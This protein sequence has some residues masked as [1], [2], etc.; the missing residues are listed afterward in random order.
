MFGGFIPT[1]VYEYLF[2]SVNK[3]SLFI[4]VKSSSSDYHEFVLFI[5]N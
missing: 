5:E 2:I 4:L 3:V 1:S